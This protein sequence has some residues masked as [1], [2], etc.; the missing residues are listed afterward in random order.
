MMKRDVPLMEMNE[1]LRREFEA[2]KKRDQPDIENRAARR[3][4][5]KLERKARK[6]HA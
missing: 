6:S 3:R 1:N 5:E 2:A 4:R